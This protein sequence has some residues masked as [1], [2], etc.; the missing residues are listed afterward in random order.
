[1]MKELFRRSALLTALILV[2]SAHIGSP[3]AWYSGTAGQYPIL[4]QVKA[5]TVVPGIAR[6]SVLVKGDG[7]RQVTASVNKF[8]ATAASPPP[9]VAVR[10]EKNPEL[11]TTDLWVMSGGSNAVT[12]TVSGD[13]GTATTII[14]VVVVATKVLQMEQPMGYGLL[15]VGVFL[16]VGAITIIASAARESV[17]EPGVE[18]DAKRRR[19]SRIAAGVATVFIAAILFGGWTWWNSAETSYKRGLFKPMTAT[20][21]TEPAPSGLKLQVAVS[22]SSWIKRRDSVWLTR[23]GRSTY[24]PLI[25]DHGKLMHLF[26]IGGP[27]NIAFV[28]LHPATQD[29]VTFTSSLPTLPAGR[30]RAFGDIVHESGFSQTL[31]SSFDIPPG[32]VGSAAFSDPDDASSIRA[33]AAGL[34]QV[35][36]DDGSELKWETGAGERVAGTEARLT[37]SVKAPDGSAA[38][39]DPYMGMAGHAVVMRDDGGVFV[40]LHPS[41]T[42][43]MASQMALVM[44]KPGDSVAGTLSKRLAGS[45][46]SAPAS[47]SG[48]SISFPYAFPQPGNYIVWVQVKRGGKVQTGAF[49]VTVK[50]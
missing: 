1:M 48:A 31:S 6:I 42:I 36:L 11:Y 3:D 41:G 28:H 7:V 44:R 47:F 30:Y 45:A 18:P 20:A 35:T 32:S 46:M 29:S 12:V 33:A 15:A 13:K 25:P 14:P 21:R 2:C 23:N 8:D 39:L 43:S 4:V 24:T 22:E 49:R 34:Q 37:F 17:L 9:D 5:P 38:V 40:H 50:S 10:D 27:D 19:I 26:V 16:L